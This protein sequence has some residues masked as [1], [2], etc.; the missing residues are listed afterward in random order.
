MSTSEAAA[1]M[2]HNYWRNTTQ[3]QRNAAARRARLGI[4]AKELTRPDWDP[5]VQEVVIG[6]L[7][8]RM[9]DLTD[10]QHGRLVDALIGGGR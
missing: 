4:V 9:D 5:D 3:E 1:E 8:G 2:S 10:D 6:V 7:C